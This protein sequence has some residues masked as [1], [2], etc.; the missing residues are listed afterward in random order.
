MGAELRLTAKDG[1]ELAAYE[2]VPEGQARGG[3]VV[4]QEIFG[5]N[6]HIREVCERFAREGYHVVAPALF[7]R[8]MPGVELGYG[9]TDIER[10]R[11]FMGQLSWR[12]ALADVAA[13]AET[14]APSGQP[15]IVGYCYGGT[16]AWVAACRLPLRCA[17]GYYGGRIIDF[18][19]E[20][21]RC[22]TML[23][24]GD[25]DTGIPNSDVRE[26]AE[27]QR[28]VTVHVYTGAQHG[29]NCDHRP[30]YDATSASLALER[31]LGFLFQQFL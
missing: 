23:H 13:A 31:T 1:H 8:I 14:L 16:V 15:G 26:I 2:V 25:R 4:V 30:S 21:P 17:V 3:L 19:D 27:K 24:F 12:G 22:P 6:E 29:F 5:V 18:V 20:T 28:E 11:N 7:D 10:G 9:P